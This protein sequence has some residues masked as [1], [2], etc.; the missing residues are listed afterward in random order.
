M[1]LHLK[2]TEFVS[3]IICEEVEV[4]VKQIDAFGYS[5]IPIFDW[6]CWM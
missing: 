4:G 3:D 6:F 5:E 1:S 2:F